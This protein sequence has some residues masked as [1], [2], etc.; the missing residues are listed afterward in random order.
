MHTIPHRRSVFTVTTKD[1][2][3]ILT[4]TLLKTVCFRKTRYKFIRST[5]VLNLHHDGCALNRMTMSVSH[6]DK[7]TTFTRKDAVR[8]VLMHPIPIQIFRHVQWMTQWPNAKSMTNQ[9]ELGP[10]FVKSVN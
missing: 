10:R 8:M 9:E 1:V 3:F 4:M 5:G 2:G 6:A 7:V